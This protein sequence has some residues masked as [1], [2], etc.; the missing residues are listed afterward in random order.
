M[1]SPVLAARLRA[2]EVLWSGWSALPEPLVAEA[3]ARAGFDCITFDVQHGLHDVASVM[4]GIGAVTLAGKPALVRMPVGD[5]GFASRVID[6]GAEAVIAPMINTAN[7]ARAFV[8]AMKYP[9]IG[10]RSWGP[11]RVLALRGIEPQAHLDTANG[12]TLALAMIET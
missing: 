1:T 2:G 12:T 4:R 7:E 8:A 11:A 10:E 6:M 3:V 5:N 9:P